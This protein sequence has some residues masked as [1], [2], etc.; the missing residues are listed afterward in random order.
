MKL[1]THLYLMSG[2]M[3]GAMP[4]PSVHAFVM[5]TGAILVLLY[6]LFFWQVIT[7]GILICK[8]VTIRLKP[9]WTLCVGKQVI[10]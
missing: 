3:G 7:C 5:C 2:L 10:T 6:E 4:L 8:S 1:I 9:D